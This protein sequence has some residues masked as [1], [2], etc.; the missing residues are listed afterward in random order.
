MDRLVE[1]EKQRQKTNRAMKL[2]QEL[3][4]KATLDN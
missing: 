2:K 3:D 4:L 1:E